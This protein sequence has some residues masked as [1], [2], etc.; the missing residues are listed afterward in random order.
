MDYPV[1][2]PGD[3]LRRRESHSP[4]MVHGMTDKWEGRQPK[5]PIYSTIGIGIAAPSLIWNGSSDII[6]IR[7]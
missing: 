3:S 4:S 2:E 5:I 1:G 6:F 7:P